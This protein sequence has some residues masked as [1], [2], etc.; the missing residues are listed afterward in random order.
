MTILTPNRTDLLSRLRLEGAKV[1]ASVHRLNAACQFSTIVI[2][3]DSVASLSTGVEKKPSVRTH[4]VGEET[5]C[6][7]LEKRNGDAGSNGGPGLT[8]TAIN[9]RSGAR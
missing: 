5:H 6:P 8:G 3:E 1:D 2:G 9:L 4:V 7:R